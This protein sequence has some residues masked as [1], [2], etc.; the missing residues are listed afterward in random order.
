MMISILLTKMANLFFTG[1]TQHS[2]MAREQFFFS[3]P[4]VPFVLSAGS[5][6]THFELGPSWSDKN[7]EK[8][9]LTFN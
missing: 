5:M 3:I 6:P 4:P 8:L 9:K 1:K 2:L 7:R